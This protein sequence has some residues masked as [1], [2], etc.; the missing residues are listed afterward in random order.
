MCG[1]TCKRIVSK[2]DIPLAFGTRIADMNLGR[3]VVDEPLANRVRSGRKQ[4]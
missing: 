4:P 1:S 2:R 3:L